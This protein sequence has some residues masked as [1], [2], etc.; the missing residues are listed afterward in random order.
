M[1]R[2]KDK[3]EI[4]RL[5]G[6]V[7]YI[8]KFIPNVS[9]ITDPMREILKNE[10]VFSWHKRQEKSFQETKELITSTRCLA[11][12][13][14]KKEVTM[15][16]DACKTGLGAVLAREGNVIAFASRSMTSAQLNYAIIEKELQVVVFACK[17]FHQFIYG[18]KVTVYSDHKPLESISNKLLA[19]APPRLQRMLL[20]L[21]KYDIQIKYKPGTEMIIADALSRSH[22]PEEGEEIPEEELN[23]QIHMIREG[24]V[25]KDIMEDIKLAT[26]SG[27]TLREVLK[28]TKEGWP[29]KKSITVTAKKYY[30]YREELAIIKNISFKD[31]L[32]SHI[33]FL[34]SCSLRTTITNYQQIEISVEVGDF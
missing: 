4:R 23:A 33:S 24:R 6:M 9:E 2:P 22:L 8:A 27:R 18:K 29:N 14:V 32:A 17:R 11:L 21:Q 1:P 5:L 19:Q 28:Y 20:C 16:V 31:S 15:E 26:I 25:A 7:N 34:F 30:S 10:V 12:Y 13:D 3:S